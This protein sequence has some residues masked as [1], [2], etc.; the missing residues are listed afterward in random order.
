MILVK[1][2]CGCFYTLK[3]NNLLTFPD[4]THPTE[5][6]CQNCGQRHVFDLDVLFA[7]TSSKSTEQKISLRNRACSRQCQNNGYVYTISF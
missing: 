3:T 2:E 5:H 1:C 6:V 4:E 7:K